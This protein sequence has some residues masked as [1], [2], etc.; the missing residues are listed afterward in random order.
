VA[1]QVLVAA[2]GK[3]ATHEQVA[4]QVGRLWHR[5]GQRV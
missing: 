2:R 1:Q 5:R 3:V 4:A